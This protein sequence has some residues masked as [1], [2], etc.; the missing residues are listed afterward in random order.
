MQNEQT[1]VRNSIH[2]LTYIQ[3]YAGTKE[4]V[5]FHV[6]L[7]RVMLSYFTSVSSMVMSP[8]STSLS[9]SSSSNKVLSLPF[10][11]GWRSRDR[12]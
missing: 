6:T 8:S 7:C 4:R 1:A 2:V 11:V 5:G 9:S 12:M 10:S 3:M